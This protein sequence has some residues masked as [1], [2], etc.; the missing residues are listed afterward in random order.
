MCRKGAGWNCRYSPGSVRY[1]Y[2][3]LINT[4]SMEI[5]GMNFQRTDS[6]SQETEIQRLMSECVLCPRNCHANRTKGQTG[7]CGQGAEISA[8][9]AALHFWEEP[10]ISGQNGSGAI[11]FSGCNLQCTFC[12]N[13]KIATGKTGKNL[14]VERLSE[15][16]LMLQEKGAHN[17]N[18]VTATHYIPHVRRA[19][20]QAK[21]QGLCIPV[22]YNTSGYEEISSL[23]TLEGL[24]DIYLPDMKYHS[25]QLSAEYSHAPD[26]F[27]KSS[28]ALK[29]MF[30][31]AGAP[32]FDADS[33]LMK[34]GVIVRHMILPGNT[35][36]SKKI[37]RYLHET[38]K[39]DIY[40]S[41]MSQY[42]PM[43]QVSSI[44]ALCRK[45]TKEEYLRVL[46]FAEQ[47]GIT[48]GFYQEGDTASESFI[49][50]F[51]YEGL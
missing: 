12:Q 42:T 45:V 18:L 36:D 48:H 7:Y 4:K 40:V 19:L 13:H 5:A 31:Q 9:R 6:C 8:A 15:I 2:G 27:E 41:I 10:C 46:H 11:F 14:S 30:R 21:S 39:N 33:G 50:E 43:P 3:A 16:F 37:L 51:D 35:K 29:E 24:V 1:L 32:V 44:P 26:Y 23:Q 49:P 22:V 28:A 38:Y 47:I 34:R 20:I 25:P 17:I